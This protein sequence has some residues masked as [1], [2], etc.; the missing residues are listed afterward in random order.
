MVVVDIKTCPQE[1][2][3]VNTKCDCSPHWSWVARERATK[4]GPP[5]GETHFTW[6]IG[7]MNGSSMAAYMCFFSFDRQGESQKLFLTM[8][9]RM[10]TQYLSGFAALP[11]PGR[12]IWPNPWQWTCGVSRT[13][14]F[15][16]IERGASSAIR[17][18]WKCSPHGKS[19]TKSDS[20]WSCFWASSS[21]EV[22]AHT[23]LCRS[24]GYIP[25]GC[26]NGQ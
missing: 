25:S 3:N 17:E 16:R 12:A 10:A 18:T 15:G 7:S 23:V 21:C 20:I 11:I 24:C 14:H 26:W 2:T 8:I 13:C 6:C 1:T 5:G 19:A 9:Y 22:V 4:I